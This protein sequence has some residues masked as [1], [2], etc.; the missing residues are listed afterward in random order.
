MQAFIKLLPQALIKQFDVCSMCAWWMHDKSCHCN[1][2]TWA[3]LTNAWLELD[4]L[5]RRASLIV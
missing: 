4:E 1:L 5:A 2:Y 3:D